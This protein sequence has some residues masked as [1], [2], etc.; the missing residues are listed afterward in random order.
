MIY[1]TSYHKSTLKFAIGLNTFD[2]NY[3]PDNYRIT[4]IIMDIDNNITIGKYNI[5]NLLVSSSEIIINLNKYLNC[6]DYYSIIENIKDLE[7]LILTIRKYSKEQ[8]IF[9]LLN[10]DNILTEYANKKI[11]IL[12]KKYDIMV[13]R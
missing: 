12:A 8:I 11:I 1:V 6:N 13:L 2:V 4:D 10:E 7:T 5:Q 3:N 9:K